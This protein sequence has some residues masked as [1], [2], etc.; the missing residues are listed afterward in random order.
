MI[1]WTHRLLAAVSLHILVCS[2]ICAP[3]IVRHPKCHTNQ[4]YEALNLLW[5]VWP[6]LFTTELW[7]EALSWIEMASICRVSLSKCA[8]IQDPAL[9]DACQRLR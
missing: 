3:D 6:A 8:D 2:Q 4:C 9:E 1:R 5:C 7:S